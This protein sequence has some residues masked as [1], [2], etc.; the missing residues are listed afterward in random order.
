MVRTTDSD[1]S[2]HRK[3]QTT[4]FASANLNT[5]LGRP[6][7]QPQRAARFGTLGFFSGLD[8]SQGR[9]GNRHAFQFPAIPFTPRDILERLGFLGLLTGL[10]KYDT[11]GSDN[12]EVGFAAMSPRARQYVDR[13]LASFLPEEDAKPYHKRPLPK[14][15]HEQA[16]RHF[17]EHANAYDECKSL[18]VLE[19]A[20]DMMYEL[21]AMQ[22]LRQGIFTPDDIARWVPAVQAQTDPVSGRAIPNPARKP[23]FTVLG[24]ITRTLSPAQVDAFQKITGMS[25]KRSR[26][27]LGLILMKFALFKSRHPELNPLQDACKGIESEARELAEHLPPD[28][29]RNQTP[30]GLAFEYIG[31]PEQSQTELAHKP[32]DKMRDKLLDFINGHL[33]GAVSC[34]DMTQYIF[35]KHLG[36]QELDYDNPGLA[37]DVRKNM[38]KPYEMLLET[39]ILRKAGVKPE[40]TP[41]EHGGAR[42]GHVDMQA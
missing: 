40:K 28:L 39:Y 20:S 36:R 15:L 33:K 5:A 22:A 27:M 34:D 32:T 29:T 30:L 16:F 7:A 25:E 4:L 21:Y 2:G 12:L 18:G 38:I 3:V 6:Q 31:R 8:P 41:C 26:T 9:Q 24:E 42:H 14:T 35:I 37:Y 19:E 17:L 1:Q 23:F 11:A 13:M 10:G